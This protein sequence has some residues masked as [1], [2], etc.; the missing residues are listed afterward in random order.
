[1]SNQIKTPEI[2]QALNQCIKQMEPFLNSIEPVMIRLAKQMEPMTQ[3]LKHLN[4]VFEKIDVEKLNSKLETLFKRTEPF[5]EGLKQVSAFLERVD[6]EELQ[7]NMDRLQKC[8]P[9][10]NDLRADIT[11]KDILI[12]IEGVPESEYEEVLIRKLGKSSAR[13][14]LSKRAALKAKQK[15][16][17][18]WGILNAILTVIS[19]C[20]LPLPKT[21]PEALQVLLRY[22]EQTVQCAHENTPVP[23]SIYQNV[24]IV[25]TGKR[26]NRSHKRR[27]NQ[28]CSFK[29]HSHDSTLQGFKLKKSTE[30]RLKSACIERLKG[31]VR[32]DM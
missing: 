25:R 26:K 5:I 31:E 16:L 30:Q 8:S 32:E 2:P 4:N 12:A 14:R 28:K 6:F 7:F 3:G 15:L 13:R 1:M 17:L 24:A 29:A 27:G 19:V 23:Q 22:P 20:E 21:I 18:T 10:L 9:Y 11:L